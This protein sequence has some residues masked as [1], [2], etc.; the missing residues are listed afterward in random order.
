MPYA[1]MQKIHLNFEPLATLQKDGPMRDNITEEDVSQTW[2]VSH[3]QEQHERNHYLRRTSTKA[4]LLF[5]CRKDSVFLLQNR[6]KTV[7]FR[8]LSFPMSHTHTPHTPHTNM[9]Y[10]HLFINC[11]LILS[12]VGRASF[13]QCEGRRS[14]T[15]LLSPSTS[16]SSAP[17]L[18]VHIICSFFFFFIDLNDLE[19]NERTVTEMSKTNA[20][21]RRNR[22]VQ[23]ATYISSKHEQKKKY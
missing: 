22:D 1:H 7:L 12:R 11:L 3:K 8:S 19:Q 6:Y 4:N 15:K 18:L 13:L 23:H 16:T 5:G 2:T 14:T 9:I 10:T 21:S 17:L 20:D